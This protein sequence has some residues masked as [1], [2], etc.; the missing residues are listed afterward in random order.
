MRSIKWCH[1]QWPWTNPNPF[2]RSHHF[3][4][5]NISQT[6]T[7]WYQAQRVDFLLLNNISIMYQHADKLEARAITWYSMTLIVQ[8]FPAMHPC[9]HL[10][11]ALPNV[12]HHLMPRLK[13]EILLSN[14]WSCINMASGIN[15]LFIFFQIC[16]IIIP[17]IWKNYFGYHKTC[18]YFRYPKKLFWIS[19]TTI[20]DIRK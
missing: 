6:A 19:K 7:V 12:F 13:Q 1:F 16:E 17:D 18:T 5:L 9:N 15:T 11:L 2:L 14:T 4:T 3:L 10:S 8:L 20:S